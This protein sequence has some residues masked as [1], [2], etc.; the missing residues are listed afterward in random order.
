M[1]ILIENIG[2]FVR[3]SAI[4]AIFIPAGSGPFSLNS[5]RHTHDLEKW[6]SGLVIKI[7]EIS[8]VHIVQISCGTISPFNA[9]QNGT[10]V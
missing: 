1:D 4:R 8:Q 6:P 7:L 5:L 2:F 9:R 3:Y 10:F